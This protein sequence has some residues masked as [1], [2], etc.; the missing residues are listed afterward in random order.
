MYEVNNI[1]YYGSVL[2]F[3]MS[4]GVVLLILL[5]ACLVL[6]VIGKWKVLDKL[7]KRPWAALI[8]FFSD[9]EMACGVT[10]PQWLVIACPVVGI[11][12][13]VLM[14]MTDGGT[15]ASL[16][17][18]ATF[19]LVCMLCYYTSKRFNKG[20]GWTVGLVLLGFVFWPIIGLGSSA[21][22]SQA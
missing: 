9:Y 22:D 18:L 3:I 6:T 19:V 2:G 10:A 8:P 13:W 20:V 17:N 14:F 4:F 12:G 1:S 5:I 16:C 11:V 21:P 15:L 7:G